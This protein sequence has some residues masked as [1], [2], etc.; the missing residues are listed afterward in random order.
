MI[1]AL[2]FLWSVTSDLHPCPFYPARA[3]TGTFLVNGV[4]WWQR[5]CSTAC[6]AFAH[7]H[8]LTQCATLNWPHAPFFKS[9]VWSRVESNLAFHLRRHLQPTVELSFKSLMR[10]INNSHSATACWNS[11][12]H[13]FLWNPYKDFAVGTGTFLKG[14]AEKVACG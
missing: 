4:H 7:T 3:L 13:W 1:L 14:R 9:S 5:N 6:E 12:A 2:Y 8:L 10:N 11:H